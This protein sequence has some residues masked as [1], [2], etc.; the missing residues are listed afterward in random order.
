[1][2]SAAL[3]ELP[4]RDLVEL[5]T[6]YLENRLTVDDRARFETHLEACEA[7]R[8]YVEQFRLTLKLLGRL[9]EDALSPEATDR[10]MAAFRGWVGQ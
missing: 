5:I 4:C 7:C 3:P 9:P 6:D 10:L 8:T 1:V 2:N